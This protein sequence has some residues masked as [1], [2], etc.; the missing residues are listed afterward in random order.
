[1][2]RTLSIGIAELE[3]GHRALRHSGMERIVGLMEE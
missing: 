2:L 3:R 1:M